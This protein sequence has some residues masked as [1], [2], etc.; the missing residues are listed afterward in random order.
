MCS[1]KTIKRVAGVGWGGVVRAQMA[2]TVIAHSNNTAYVHE[3][4]E[5]SWAGGQVVAGQGVGLGWASGNMPSP[6]RKG[7]LMRTYGTVCLGAWRSGLVP[8]L[9]CRHCS[10]APCRASGHDHGPKARA[11]V[12]WRVVYTMRYITHIHFMRYITH[13]LYT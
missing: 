8:C 13:M 7:L 12:K 1:G 3:H 2:A 6:L 9:L 4:T 11:S 5:R 10:Q